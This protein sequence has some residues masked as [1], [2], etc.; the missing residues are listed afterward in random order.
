M[1]LA[2]YSA[3]SSAVVADRPAG[4]HLRFVLLTVMVALLTVSAAIVA[5]RWLQWRTATSNPV[6]RPIDVAGLFIDSTPVI[7]TIEAGGAYVERHTTADELR[8]SR[9]LWRMMHLEHWN[10]VPAPLRHDVLDRMFEAYRGILMNPRAWDRMTTTDWDAVPQP[11]R[12]VA[13]RQMVAYWAGYYDVGG[14]YDLPPGRV[15]DTLAAIVMSESWF[16]HRGWFVNRDGSADIGL[17]AASE[18]ARVRLRQLHADGVVD[19]SFADDDYYNPWMATRFV[20]VWMSLLLD[21]ADGDLALAVRA[22]NRGIASAGDTLGTAYLA[23]VERR[24]TR[25]I[26]NQDA[27]L[28]W[29]YLWHRARELERQEW[30]WT[31]QADPLDRSLRSTRNPL[32]TSAIAFPLPVSGI[33]AAAMP[34][35]SAHERAD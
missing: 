5:V 30:P 10:L 33:P 13:Y 17:G 15:A 12:T 20:A 34:R 6:V 11:M 24:L 2:I 8:R 19:V 21:E 23:A 14:D 1:S 35:G 3:H 9:P 4:R 18:F 28:A 22:Y 32:V 29:S 27:P 16:N 7:I 25:F 26:R 31:L